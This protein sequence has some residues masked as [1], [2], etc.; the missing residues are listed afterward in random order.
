MPNINVL[1]GFMEASLRSRNLNSY[2]KTAVRN[3]GV[4][5]LFNVKE[6]SFQFDVGYLEMNDMNER[7]PNGIY[8]REPWTRNFADE[9]PIEYEAFV[10]MQGCDK[11]YQ[12]DISSQDDIEKFIDAYV[13]SGMAL[14][15]RKQLRLLQAQNEAHDAAEKLRRDGDDAAAVA[16]CVDVNA[17]KRLVEQV[18]KEV[19]DRL[20]GEQQNPLRN[21]VY[22]HLIELVRQN[23]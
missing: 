14:Q 17:V 22:N 23:W 13:L 5:T 20:S 19:I 9:R 10:Q 15:T 16:A 1:I 2:I 18:K 8:I 12:T 11:P 21:R 3:S 7:S 6:M 4:S